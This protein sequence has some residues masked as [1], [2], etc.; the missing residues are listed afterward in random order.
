MSKPRINPPF[1][2]VDV[3]IEA[4]AAICLIYM[5]IQLIV[6]YPDLN[7]KVPTHFG[8]SGAPD[9]WG[10]K[11]SMLIIPIVSIVLYVGLTLLNQYPH[12]FNYP[13][14]ITEENANRQYQYAKS[15]LTTLKFTTCGLFLYI[16]LQTISVAKQ[17]QSGLGTYFLVVLLIGS[18]IPIVIYF[19]IS[20]RNK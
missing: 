6:V 2:S 15:L 12:L 4:L 19:V 7:Q 14:P 20:A 3:I 17:I 1:R 11:S 10:D 5:I 8:S 18:F 13:I 16:Q 9:A